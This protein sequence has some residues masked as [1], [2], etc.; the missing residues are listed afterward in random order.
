LGSEKRKELPVKKAIIILGLCLALV[1]TTLGC[2]E[3]EG[4]VEINME[5]GVS[6]LV[7]LADS[8]I[9]GYVNSMEPLAM[10]QE[11]QSGQWEDM[12]GLLEKV[13]DTQVAATVWFVLP[14]GSYY[15]VELGKT[16]QNLS[17]RDY[18]PGLMA[19]NEVLGP[20]VFSKSTGKISLI[21]AVPVVREGDVIGALGASIFLDDLSTMLAAA[22]DLPDDMVFCATDDEGNIALHSDTELILEQNPDLPQ[23]VVFKTSLLT[24]WR[25]ALGFKD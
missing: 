3:G 23:K 22:L 15:T 21:T 9:E 11:V 20:L 2:G 10:T 13:D 7:A 1:V 24:G 5:M 14:N 12:V 16:D 4:S 18:F 19:G 8:Y 17:D 6:A 25:F